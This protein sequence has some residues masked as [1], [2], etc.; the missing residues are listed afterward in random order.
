MFKTDNLLWDT[1]INT[2]GGINDVALF[3]SCYS[4]TSSA[5]AQQGKISN[6]ENLSP[7]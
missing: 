6:G 5:Y 1:D 7:L 2:A 4:N 3:E